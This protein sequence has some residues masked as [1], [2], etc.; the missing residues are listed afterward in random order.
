M[1]ISL[2]QEVTFMAHAHPIG[3]PIWIC[4]A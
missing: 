2:H 3:E 1:K 4:T